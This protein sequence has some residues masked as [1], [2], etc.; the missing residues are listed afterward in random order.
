MAD[1]LVFQQIVDENPSPFLIFSRQGK[2]SYCNPAGQPVLLHFD[3]DV[4]GQV[5]PKF[6]ESIQ[7]I[8][9]PGVAKKIEITEAG[10]VIELTVT[11]S[12]HNDE[13]LCYGRDVTREKELE[14]EMQNQA[15]YEGVSAMITTYAHEISNPLTIAIGFLDG[16]R[17]KLDDIRLQKVKAALERISVII[18][19]IRSIATTEQGVDL[20]S[21]AGDA[22]MLDLKSK[23]TK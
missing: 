10:L 5:S 19:K 22:K 14:A 6:M 17:E 18:A 16:P 9:T 20:E 2:I 1:A 12:I 23:G 3:C 4:G 11:L 21:Y 8:D 15:R 7:D 13:Y